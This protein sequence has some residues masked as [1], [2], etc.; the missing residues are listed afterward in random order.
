MVE[1]EETVRRFTRT[2]LEMQGYRVLEALDGESALLA[3]EQHKDAEIHLLVTD[4][5]MPGIGGREV[6]RRFRAARPEG[7]VLFMSGYTEDALFDP[8]GA[9]QGAT[10]FIHKPFTPSGLALEV[11]EMLNG[12]L[13]P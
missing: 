8:D 5:V 13:L 2:I 3:N 6:A 12:S 9:P 11:R 1:D 4:M 10:R 7:K